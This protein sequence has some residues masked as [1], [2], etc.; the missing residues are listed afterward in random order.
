VNTAR[1]LSTAKLS[2]LQVAFWKLLKGFLKW[3]LAILN[4]L[5]RDRIEQNAEKYPNILIPIPNP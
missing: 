1:Q 4:F 5:Q 2:R 3:G